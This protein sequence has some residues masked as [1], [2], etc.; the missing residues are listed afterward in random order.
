[1]KIMK[2]DTVYNV[3]E[4]SKSW[5]VKKESDKLSVSFDISKELCKTEQE[6]REYVLSD[7]EL[8]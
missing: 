6:L 4:N 5:I 3:S 7:N 2:G 1:M 8:F